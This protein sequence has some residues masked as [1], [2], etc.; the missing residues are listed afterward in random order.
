MAMTQGRSGT[1]HRAAV[2]KRKFTGLAAVAAGTV[3]LV[4]AALM[5]LPTQ[6]FAATATVQLGTVDAYSVFGS[7]AV[8]NTGPST[9][10]GDLGL[11]PADASFITGFPPGIVGGATNAANGASLQARND[12]TAAYNDA[13][14]RP[15]TGGQIGPALVGKTLTSGVYKASTS[16]DLGGPL[17]LNGQGD[18]NAVFIF[19]IGSTLVTDSASSVIVSNGAQACN[20]FWQVG[21]SATLGTGSTFKGTIMALT[22]VTVTTGT[23]VEGRALARNGA[24]TLDNNVFSSPSCATPSAAGS[25]AS[26]AASAYLAASSSAAAASSA[27]AGS[28]AAA[29]ASSA[30]VLAAQASSSSVAAAA[31]RSAAVGTGTGTELANT[32]PRKQVG[33]LAALGF[34]LLAAGGLLL[35][36]GRRRRA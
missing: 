5:A 9:L 18:P 29:A 14:G 22:S 20:V 6:A 2:T 3:T 32:G 36:L 30:A 33:Q 1:F 35:A 11:D 21:S 16:L 15:A 10:S 23:T 13:A 7:T 28:V 24:V 8:T 27:S 19:Q 17:T 26:S 31:A 34:T 12:L 25:S 4:V